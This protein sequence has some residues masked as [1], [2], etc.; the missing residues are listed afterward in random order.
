[1]DFQDIYTDHSNYL[2]NFVNAKQ[3][4][5]SDAMCSDPIQNPLPQSSFRVAK[6]SVVPENGFLKVTA[7]YI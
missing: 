7:I 6:K 2:K 4:Y 3:N 5:N 1:M